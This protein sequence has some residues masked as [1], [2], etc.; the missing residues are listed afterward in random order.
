[1]FLEKREKKAAGREKRKRKEHLAFIAK[2]YL[3]GGLGVQALER[4][5]SVEDERKVNMRKEKKEWSIKSIFF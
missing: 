2:G 4:E 5:R 3:L 1:M